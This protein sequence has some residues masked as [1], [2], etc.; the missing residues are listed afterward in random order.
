MEQLKELIEK[1]NE[2][3]EKQNKI[4]IEGFRQLIWVNAKITDKDLVKTFLERV[5]K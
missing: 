4:L 3:L 5:S 2:I 1:Q